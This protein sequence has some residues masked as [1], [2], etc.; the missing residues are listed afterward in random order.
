LMSEGKFSLHMAH[1]RDH[2]H[3]VAQVVR[4]RVQAD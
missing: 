3:N 1:W 4:Q 2:I